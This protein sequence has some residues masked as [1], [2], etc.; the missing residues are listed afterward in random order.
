MKL[1][2]LRLRKPTSRIAA[3]PGPGVWLAV[4]RR[5]RGPGSQVHETPYGDEVENL[6]PLHLV[7]LWR[8]LAAGQLVLRRFP[9]AARLVGVEGDALNARVL[10]WVP[11]PARLHWA[12]L[13]VDWGLIAEIALASDPALGASELRLLQR[14]M[15]RERE[16]RFEQI[17]R[18]YAPRGAE[19]GETAS[20]AGLPS[21]PPADTAYDTAVDPQP[22]SAATGAAAPGA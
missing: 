19:A 8:P 22:S 10:R 9:A 15:H 18:R 3:A 21:E 1:D 17:R 5:L 7:A 16:R 4:Q 12:E 6:P 20:A 14:V 13:E 2:L 11:A